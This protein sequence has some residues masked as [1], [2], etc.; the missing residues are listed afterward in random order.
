MDDRDRSFGMNHT[1]SYHQDVR[2]ALENLRDVQKSTILKILVVV[3]SR[4]FTTEK[5][6]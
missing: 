6:F 3:R 2:T 1:S 5:N 4:K